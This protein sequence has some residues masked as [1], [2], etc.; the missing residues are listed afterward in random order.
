MFL[1]CTSRISFNWAKE[2]ESHPCILGLGELDR[3]CHLSLFVAGTRFSSK[4]RKNSSSDPSGCCMIF[5][6]AMALPVGI[7]EIERFLDPGLAGIILVGSGV[8]LAGGGD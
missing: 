4:S 2:L 5:L 1:L 8:G 6:V 7:G 3:F